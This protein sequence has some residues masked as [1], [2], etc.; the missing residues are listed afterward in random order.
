ML[1]M[2]A[3]CSAVYTGRGDTTLA[4]CRRA[5][6]VKDDGSVSIHSGKGTKPLNYMGSPNVLT[7]MSDDDGNEVWSFDTRRESLQVT[8][9]EVHD[10]A[11]FPLDED[12][13]GLVRDGTEAHLQ[14]WLADRP[15]TFGEGYF[16]IQREYQTGA[17]PVDL[18][19]GHPDG[20]VLAVEVKRVAMLPSVDQA[21]RYV[22][23][24]ADEF[25]DVRGVVV[26]RDVRPKTR[27]QAD[28][29][30]ISWL[31]VDW[32]PRSVSLAS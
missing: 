15:E 5:I 17:G 11:D 22:T 32:M 31:E 2:I 6:I 23:A 25:D 1:T 8:L 28:K 14:E 29:K 13:P 7:V 4:P 21:L 3:T 18:L 10:K 16:L 12:D 24:L 20:H 27:V 26:A 30:G 19:F 9:F